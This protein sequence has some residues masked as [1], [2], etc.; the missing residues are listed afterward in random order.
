M[1]YM[2]MQIRVRTKIYIVIR[3]SNQ[4]GISMY[5]FIILFFVICIGALM[6]K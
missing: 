5:I 1:I 6:L 3:T 2:H 4:R